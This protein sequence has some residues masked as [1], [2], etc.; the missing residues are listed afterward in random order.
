MPGRVADTGANI[1]RSPECR[2]MTL[3]IFEVNRAERGAGLLQGRASLKFNELILET[4]T[5]RKGGDDLVTLLWSIVVI[6]CS[7]H[8]HENTRLCKSH[9]GAHVLGNAGSGMEGD[10]F[11][12]EVRFGF[13]DAMAPEE[14]AGGVSAINFKPFC[15]RV[16]LIDKT[17]VMKQRRYI[18]ELGVEL[19]I[20][21]GSLHGAKHVNANGV[22]E[23]YLRFMLAHQ[24]RRFSRDLAVGQLDTRNHLLGERAAGAEAERQ[25]A[26]AGRGETVP[27]RHS[28]LPI[29]HRFLRCGSNRA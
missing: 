23:Q 27:A 29:L 28:V 25:R 26:G 11:P 15:L 17:Q 18:E 10:R 5:A 7:E 8:V 24:L 3:D 13:G 2:I 22:V 19:N 12:N 20:L 4:N 16:V 9:F 21:A 14:F 1:L 6:P